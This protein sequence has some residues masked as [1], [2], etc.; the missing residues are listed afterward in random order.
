VRKAIVI[1]AGLGGLATAVRLAASG[2]DVTVLEKNVAIG[3]RCNIYQQA[4]YTF[5]TGPSILLM[6]DVLHE[7]FRS[8]GRDMRE[9]LDLIRLPFNYRIRFGDGEMLDVS[10]DALS[11]AR[12]MEAM[13]PGA[14]RQYARYLQDA[15][16][17]YRVA[18]TR[19]TDRNF[20]AW[21]EFFT[22]PNLYYMLRTNTLSKLEP[23]A[24]RYFH[25]PRLRLALTFQTMY[26]GLSPADAPAIYS[27]LAYTELVHGIWYPR[28]GMYEI[29][30]ALG[31]L[32]AE[33][34]GE[35]RV[36]AEVEEIV[37]RHGKATGARLKG[38]QEIAADVVVCNADLPYSYEHLIPP[39][40]RAPYA[41]G[42]LEKLR[43]GCS[44]FMLYLG[45]DRVYESLF[46]HNVF[47][48][49]DASANFRQIFE[50]QRLPDDPSFYVHCP[51]RTDP[52]MAPAGG[53]AVYV[54]APVP[55]LQGQVDW[56]VDGPAFRE[57][58]LDKVEKLAAPGI[59][60]HLVTERTVTPADWAEMYNLRKGATFGLS[61]HFAQVGYFR[62][63]N[64]A[65]ALDHLYFVGASTVPGGGVPMV[66]I[67]SRLVTERVLEEVPLS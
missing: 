32:L 39:R 11:M 13:E 41:N 4:G 17:K 40:F 48:S 51:T 20:R 56:R 57:R 43:Y 50:E 24:S 59:R 30:R 33:L 9:Y 55:S 66:F 6:V 5:D 60:G 1:G 36:G 67:S 8:A 47:L 64:R 16:Y 7:L 53:D 44:A 42:K 38:G 22:L 61:H 45:T 52:G 37:V 3:G 14:G 54:L 35:V 18:R 34:G 63:R 23:F 28:G 46:H 10:N 21:N 29:P 25:D 27:L 62:P 26:L 19:F 15:G 49:Q 58:L 65:S 12:Q 31:R 2:F